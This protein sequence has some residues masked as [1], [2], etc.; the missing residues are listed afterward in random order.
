MGTSPKG[1]VSFFTL[2]VFGEGDTAPALAIT[3]RD[4]RC[5]I[6]SLDPETARQDGRV[7]KKVFALNGNNAG[8]YGT[9]IRPGK[10][11]VEQVVNLILG[12]DHDS[13]L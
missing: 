5:T 7:M 4:V 9:V 6:I 11:N 8:V 13:D 1:G 2:D 12:Q 10:I 3:Q